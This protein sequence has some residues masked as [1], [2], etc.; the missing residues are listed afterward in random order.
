[1]MGMSLI[2]VVIHCPDAATQFGT[3]PKRFTPCF[4]PVRGFAQ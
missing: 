2:E 4:E 3:L 1:M